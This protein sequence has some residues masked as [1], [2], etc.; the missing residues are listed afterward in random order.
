MEIS[1]EVTGPGLVAPCFRYA[2]GPPQAASVPGAPDASVLLLKTW[3]SVHAALQDGMVRDLGAVPASHALAGVTC[4]RS[5]GLLRRSDPGPRRLLNPVW[6]RTSAETLRPAIREAAR[7]CASAARDDLVGGFTVPYVH[8]VTRLVTGLGDDDAAR[9]KALSDKTTGA[10]IYCPGDRA[11]VLAS[12]DQL[13]GWTYDAPYAVDSMIGRSVTALHDAGTPGDEAHEVITTV[14]NGLPTVRPAMV[15]VL[16]YLLR[17]PEVMARMAGD[18]TL[19]RSGTG[20]AMRE[21]A[22][23]TFGLPGQVMAGFSLDGTQVPAGTVVLPVIAAAHQDPSFPPLMHMAWGAGL[24][25]C[26]GRHVAAVILE[27]GVAAVAARAPR[28]AAAPEEL[29]WQPGTMPVPGELPV[30]W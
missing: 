20:E 14:Y 23:F 21:A 12:W 2:P 19:L 10:L 5:H 29:S 25:A 7:S 17:W 24:H 15:R 4:Q 18:R 28:P 16:E 9:L 1:H 22:C 3:R 27:E 26:L 13:Y 6:R 8:Q 11:P 30:V